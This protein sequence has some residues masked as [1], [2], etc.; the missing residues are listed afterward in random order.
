MN[1]GVKLVLEECSHLHTPVYEALASEPYHFI[2]GR[3]ALTND[4]DTGES[5]VKGYRY[6][7]SLQLQ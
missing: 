6:H 5:D 2:I 4:F 3:L 1:S 7:Q